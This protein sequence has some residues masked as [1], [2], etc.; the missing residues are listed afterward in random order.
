MLIMAKTS[1]YD[2]LFLF[3][4]NVKITQNKGCM[5]HSS[6]FYDLPLSPNDYEHKMVQRLTNVSTVL[7]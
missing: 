1:L 4:T 7:D 3:S 5:Y 2:L 6:Y